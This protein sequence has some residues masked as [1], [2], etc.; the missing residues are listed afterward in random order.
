MI[1]SYLKLEVERR[2]E[3]RGEERRLRRGEE[4]E[5]RRGKVK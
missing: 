3:K 1:R 4:I 2:R 5:E